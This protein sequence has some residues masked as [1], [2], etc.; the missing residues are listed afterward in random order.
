VLLDLPGQVVGFWASQFLD[1][2]HLVLPYRMK[3][4][5]LYSPPLPAGE[6]L[7]CHARIARVGDQRL[8][9]ELDVVGEDGRVRARFEG[10]E[11]RRFDLPVPALQMLVRPQ[12]LTLS[13]GWTAPVSAP[14]LERLVARRLGPDALPEEM[15]AAHGGLWAR[16]LAAL[17]L[18]RREREQWHA[19][20]PSDRRRLEW[21]RGR[22][23]AKDAVRAHVA[24]HHGLALLPADVELL[25][26][27]HG[28]PTVQGAWTGGLPRVP[29]VSI[30]HLHGE[31]V[32]VAGEGDDLLGVGVD[33]ER[34]GRMA[35]ET[36]SVAFTADELQ[37][38]DTVEAPEREAWSLRFW[39]AK[40][41]C[42]KAT[43]RGLASGPHSFTVRAMDRQGGL[44]S[45]RFAPPERGPRDLVALTAQD[46]DWIV[47]TCATAAVEGVR[48]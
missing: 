8:S 11:D 10:W 38:L 34:L 7:R 3:S 2:G 19:L 14:G 5:K 31:A 47:A 24:R 32:A 36:A 33:L 37:M 13:R 39:C 42:A 48:P 4:L 22:I 17:V 12:T 18:S 45:V 29:H 35:R 44:V 26:D 20:P 16:V 43:G 25:P 1:R 28:R 30:S 41:A 23:A 9:S 27:P 21:L 46:G 6:R 40:E 15:L